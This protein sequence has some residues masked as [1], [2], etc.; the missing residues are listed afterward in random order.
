MGRIPSGHLPTAPRAKSLFEEW[1]TRWKLHASTRS[2]EDRAEYAR[3]PVDCENVVPKERRG[4]LRRPAWRLSRSIA[5]PSVCIFE[6]RD[7]CSV[8]QLSGS[9][10]GNFRMLH[11]ANRPSGYPHSV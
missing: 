4:A 8:G 6:G 11:L 2:K 7:P 3:Q 1:K 9:P 5:A 10:V